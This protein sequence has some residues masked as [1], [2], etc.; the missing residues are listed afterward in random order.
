GMGNET[1]ALRAH[2]E[3]ARRAG[4]SLVVRLVT[5]GWRDQS[6][7]LWEPNT[8]VP[9]SLPRLNLNG[10]HLLITEV[11]FLRSPGRG[12]TAE[13]TLMPPEAFKPQ[14]INLTPFFGDVQGH[15]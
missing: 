4:R 13:I 5:D 7:A 8:L 10:V 12:T 1:A 14:P 15:L 9:V 11:T 2:W 3:A 6:E